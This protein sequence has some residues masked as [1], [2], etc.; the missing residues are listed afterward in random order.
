MDV[1][2]KRLHDKAKLPIFKTDGSACADVV[3]VTR[4]PDG[5]SMIY[6]LGFAMQIPKG[7]HIKVN[8]RSG[9]GFSDNIRLCNS[10]GIIDSDYRGPVLVKLQYDGPHYITPDWPWVGDRVAQFELVKNVKTK[11]E[12]ADELDETERG[13]G[14]F[15]STGR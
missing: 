4:T 9:H 3:S 14:G 11:Y 2:I 12:W 15:G 6:E 10:V 8:S 5:Q 1:L 7:Y 13:S